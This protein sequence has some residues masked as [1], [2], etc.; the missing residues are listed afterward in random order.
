MTT[1]LKNQA[2]WR[3]PCTWAKWA[4]GHP[5]LQIFNS[6]LSANRL[7]HRSHLLFTHKSLQ[8]KSVWWIR[9]H[10]IHKVCVWLSWIR[11]RH[12]N[13]SGSGSFHQHAQK[14][15]KSWFLLLCDFFLTFYLR[16]L[17]KMYHQNLISKKLFY[18][19]FVNHWQKNRIRI[20]TNDI[21]IRI[22]KSVVP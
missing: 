5:S 9:I 4:G 7:G 3:E 16:I 12:L 14:V 8:L 22:Q 1:S 15:R 10:R 18:W 19:H 20:R 2:W 13:K 17:I 6:N 11:I 21:Q